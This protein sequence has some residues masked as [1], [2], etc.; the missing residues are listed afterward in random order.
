[1]TEEAYT[2]IQ[3]VIA[4][5]RTLSPEILCPRAVVPLAWGGVQVEWHGLHIEIEVEVNPDRSFGYLISTP[6]SGKGGRMG[7]KE[8]NGLS[9]IEIV[10]RV[11]RVLTTQPDRAAP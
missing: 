3:H 7:F 5:N 10:Q 11:S 8:G 9:L 6:G 2:L 1:M 4:V